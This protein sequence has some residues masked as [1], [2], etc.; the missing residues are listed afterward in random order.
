MN[1]GDLDKKLYVSISPSSVYTSGGHLYI[2][3][4]LLIIGIGLNAEKIQ[5]LILE[6]SIS[7]SRLIQR[8]SEGSKMG[9]NSLVQTSKLTL[10]L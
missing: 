10:D 5:T 9:Y 7:Q 2:N 6:F 1:L 4:T 3:N 8:D